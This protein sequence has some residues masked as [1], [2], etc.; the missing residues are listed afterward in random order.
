MCVATSSDPATDDYIIEQL[1]DLGIEQARVDYDYDSADNHV[2]RLLNRLLDASFQVLLHLVQPKQSAACME[3]GEAQQEWRDFVSTTLDTYGDRVVAVEIG[4]T[5]NRAR[6][7]GYSLEGFA[8]AWDI[9]YDEARARGLVIAGPNI[10][11]YEPLYTIGVLHGLRERQRIPDI[12]TNNLFVERAIQ[13]EIADASVSGR[14]LAPVTKYNVIKKARQLR[15][16]AI[17]HGAMKMW[18]G[19][20]TWTLPR[21]AR[22]VPNVEEKQADYLARYMVLA[23]ASG[24]MER[25]YWGPLISFREGLIDDPHSLN[26]REELVTFY[27]TVYGPSTY[28]RQRPAFDALR[29]F[30]RLIPGSRYLG[31]LIP[32]DGLE[33]HA[34]LSDTYLVHVVWTLNALVTD[35][36][37]L[38]HRADLREATGYNRD[39]RSLTEQP[40]VATERPL[41]LVWSAGKSVSVKPGARPIKGL[42]V[43]LIDAAGH[44]YPVRDDNWEGMVV[45]RDRAHADDLLAA[46][47]PER[48]GQ[49][50]QAKLLR[51]A[52]NAIWTVTDPTDDNRLLVI[53]QPVKLRAH[54]KLFERFKVS[55]AKRSWTGACE[56]LR[57]GIDSPHPVAYFERANGPGLTENWYLCE[58]HPG[59]LSVRQFFT[60]YAQGHTEFEGFSMQAFLS[61]LVPFL[62]HLHGRGVY[63]RDLSGGNVLVRN[64]AGTLSFSLIDT[65]RAR[66]YLLPITL[67]KRISD[68]KRI[69]HKLHWEGRVMLLTM[70][71][72]AIGRS[73][74][75]PYRIPFHLYDLKA[76][77][78]RLL[79]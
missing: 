13:P 10:T 44:Y 36:S 3:T 75:L 26:P 32:D 78:K 23:A 55:K 8:N 50:P 6:W 42:S 76:A 59:Q 64:N 51:K 54:K 18:N 16:T 58:F 60:A 14:L 49:L 7:A 31:R 77:T 41:Y 73:F 24:A 63:F 4:S 53:K 12:Y 46:L 22:R 19:Y 40:T 62:V 30:A 28:Y 65:A 37:T 35:L 45:A 11:D 69:C 61:Q 70:Y 57:R 67:P 56:L 38:Y 27:G 68:L 21:I 52:R 71:L 48:I 74:S 5:I 9:A 72:E 17:R 2:V 1:H 39:G 33:V 25:V 43:N 29:Q 66:F 20:V 47:H 34:F 15:R 79:R